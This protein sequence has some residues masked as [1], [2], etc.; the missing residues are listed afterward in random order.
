MIIRHATAEDLKWVSNVHI[1]CFPDSFSTHL[2]KARGGALQR[3]FY[4]EYYKDVP[5]LFLV[6][7]DD[8]LPQK[9]I[10]GFCM[11]YYLDKGNYMDRFIKNNLF[12]VMMRTVFLLLTANKA[13][14]KKLTSRFSKSGVFS[15]VNEDI[16]VVN[17]DSGDLL[18]ICVLPEY[19]GC[20]AAQHLIEKYQNVLRERGKKL[21]LL[22]VA[23][24]NGRAVRFYEKNGF[25]AY[26][27]IAGKVRTYAKVL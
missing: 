26:K 27:E 25:V 7:E 1:R 15:V 14:W 4:E 18:S 19:Q 8:T 17:E 5:E 10:V 23:I 6:A 11:G 12:S 24:D 2:G 22:T 16:S 9:K 13:A 20:G 3:K 21:C